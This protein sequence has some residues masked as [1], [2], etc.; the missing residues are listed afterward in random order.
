MFFLPLPEGICFHH[1]VHQY[2]DKCD[3]DL[4]EIVRFIGDHHCAFGFLRS[5]LE[6]ETKQV[7]LAAIKFSVLKVLIRH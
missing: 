6:V 3:L 7:N 2:F 4:T 1:D 5:I